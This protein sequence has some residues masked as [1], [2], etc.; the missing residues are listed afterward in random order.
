MIKNITIIYIILQFAFADI[1]FAQSV[2]IPVIDNVT[3][4]LTSQKV[5]INWHVNS[6]LLIDG[7]IIKRQI[8]GETGVVEGSFNTIATIND[9]NQT[10][11]IDNGTDFGIA[12]PELGVET[13][14]IAAFKDDAGVIE[15]SNMSGK[16]STLYL[17]P[18]DFDL[19]L[20][21][22]TIYWSAFKNFGTDIGGYRIYYK[23]NIADIPV[24]LNE[25]SSQDTAFIHSNVDANVDYYYFIQVFN[26][27]NSLQSSSNIQLVT[28]T[29]PVRPAIMNADFAS[30]NSYQKVDL[31]FTVDENAI[32]NSY[33]LLKSDSIYGTYDTLA[34]FPAGIAEI[35]YTDYIKASQEILY[36]KVI[37][38]NTCNIKS[39]E[40][41]IA[42]NILLEAYANK[43]NSKINILNWTKYKT[44]LGG[45]DNY[46]IYRSVDEA[47]FQLIE[48]LSSNDTVYK[49]DVTEFV[50]PELNGNATKGHFCYYIEATEGSGNPYG[51]VGISKSNISCAH[52]ETV[53][54]IPTAFNPYSA[55]DENRSFKPVISFVNDY[56]LVVYNRWGEIVF[57]SNNSMESWDGSLNGQ[58]C[59]KGTYVYH[60]KYR[61]KNNELIEKSGQINLIY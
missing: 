2:E 61:T 29:M 3:V 31:S 18:V 16:A 54:Y 13:Y 58:I 21:Q 48:Q 43:D 1:L 25:V 50:Q 24:L 20:E 34:A 36:Y 23:N 60:L 49:D 15:Y 14:R 8:F 46:K 35:Y 28:T 45:V 19:C 10:T 33:V 39:K 26:I 56:S 6:P 40:S 17:Y 5:T 53:I 11:Y 42:H 32:L 44:W 55:K 22:N 27:D 52:Q 59:K 37:S 51:I 12:E 4:D 47:D 9:R 38:L 57:K 41:N 30:I 7:Y